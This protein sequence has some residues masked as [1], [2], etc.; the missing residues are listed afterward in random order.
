[1]GD[2]SF[3]LSGARRILHESRVIA[4]GGNAQRQCSCSLQRRKRCGT[5]TCAER[6]RGPTRVVGWGPGPEIAERKLGSLF[7]V[8]QVDCVRAVAR[9]AARAAV[10]QGAWIVVEQAPR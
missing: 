3:R 7:G 5:V 1:M 6:E 9:V 4:K 10:V 8:D 2:L